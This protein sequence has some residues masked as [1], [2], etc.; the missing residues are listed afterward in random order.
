MAKYHALGSVWLGWDLEE[1]TLPVSPRALRTVLARYGKVTDIQA[2]TWSRLYRYPVAN[3][4]QLA[5]ITLAK[6]IPSHITMAGNRVL[7]SY[8]GQPMT[9]YGCNDT[10]HLYHACPLRRSVQE[11]RPTTAT[12]SW[13]DI[14]TRGVA[15]PFQVCEDTFIISHNIQQLF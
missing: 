11:T 10:G 12:S 3:G 8:E 15:Q 13:A 1:F 9:C 4:I 14:A 6:H 5:I 2:E 7:V